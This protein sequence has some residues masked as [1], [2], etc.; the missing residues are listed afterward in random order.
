MLVG[1]A[2]QDRLRAQLL[3]D[4]LA[5]HLGIDAA[6]VH[7]DGPAGG[8]AARVDVLVVSGEASGSARGWD[9]GPR[10]VWL[11]RGSAQ[12]IAQALRSGATGVVDDSA[13]LHD[14]AD[15]VLAVARG[16]AWL[17]PARVA[18]VLAVLAEDRGGASHAALQALSPREREVLHLVGQGLTR[19]E[20][21]AHLVVSPH[22]AR[23]HV[24]NL[25][26]K[27]DV[28]SQVALA[29]VARRLGHVP[30]ARS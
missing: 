2:A 9:G 12:E 7:P 20:I 8:R 19:R 15:A 16:Q 4:Y 30:D 23:T 28:H 21:A 3:R 22:T 13:S 29:A 18:E 11:E 24:Q 17:P 14:V 27:L 6:L 10:L 25:M 5:G 26:L 1:I